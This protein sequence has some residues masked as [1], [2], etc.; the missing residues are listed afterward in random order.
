MAEIRDEKYWMEMEKSAL[1]IPVELPAGDLSMD[2]KLHTEWERISCSKL[3]LSAP[4]VDQYISQMG[5]QL[6]NK[7]GR[8]RHTGLQ[9]SAPIFIPYAIFKQINKLA[10][11]YKAKST[12]EWK[13]NKVTEM[14]LTI[15]A[16]ANL[17]N[18]FHFVR[19]G[20]N[21]LVKYRTIK[22]ADGKKV[23]GGHARIL[24]TPTTP[25]SSTTKRSHLPV[26]SASL[27]NGT[28]ITTSPRMQ[29]S[30]P[31]W[32]AP[33]PGLI[34]LTNQF[35]CFIRRAR[36]SCL[37][38]SRRKRWVWSQC[39]R[40][41]ENSNL[42]RE[43]QKPCKKNKMKVKVVGKMRNTVKGEL[44]RSNPF[45]FTKCGNADC[46]L[47][48][49]NMNIDCRT[50]G[51]RKC[52][53]KYQGQTSRSI[54]T[55]SDIHEVFNGELASDRWSTLYCTVWAKSQIDVIEI[56]TYSKVCINHIS[57]ENYLIK[58]RFF[59]KDAQICS[60]YA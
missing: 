12:V 24:A 9:E 38:S 45:K 59:A 52:Q 53:R 16:L 13:K 22:T 6:L 33:S 4:L 35:A 41:I 31:W 17:K 54:W 23:N 20:K 27:Y 49:L 55:R 47:C 29:L 1:G 2:G 7:L 46:V 18:I 14:I 30:N 40:E 48:S 58:L 11:N 19:R 60:A 26:D 10:L 5:G 21:Y 57:A 56:N 42:M 34:R 51:C 32:T 50:R 43:V 3:L 36:Q 8:G 28:T 44:Q 37:N 25:S 39:L 15:D